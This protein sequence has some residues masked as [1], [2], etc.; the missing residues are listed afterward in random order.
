MRAWVFL[1]L[2]LSWLEAFSWEQKGK[3]GAV[4]Y[5]YSHAANELALEGKAQIKAKNDSYDAVA[6]AQFLYSS[7]YAQRRYILLDELFVYAEMEEYALSLGRQMKFWGE[8]EGFNFTDIYNPKNLLQDPFDKSAKY[9][10]WGADIVRYFDEN[11]LEFGVKFYEEDMELPLGKT[12]YALIPVEYDKELRV[13]KS[14]YTPTLYLKADITTEEWL[15]SETT[16]ILLH[17]YD[18]KRGFMLLTPT[19]IAQI[20]YVVDKALLHTHILYNDTIFKA[21]VVY[22]HVRD[23][24]PVGD[25]AQIAAGVEH[26]LY[27]VVGSADVGFFGEYYRYIYVDASK[28]KNIDIAELFDDDL[29]FALRASFNDTHSSVLKAGIVQ[30][31]R[32]KERLLK[33]DFSSRVDENFTFK[34]QYLQIFSIAGETVLARFGDSSRFMAALNYNF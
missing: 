26:T 31:R 16:L 11:S 1:L 30:D 6:S 4:A 17:G 7:E 34:A 21:E 13:T 18:N 24:V 2:C 29:F 5:A 9:G 14:R 23:S 19:K 33:V 10:A 8:M 15:E 27:E 22:T 12:P 20:A 3:I 25:Y 28:Q 32:K